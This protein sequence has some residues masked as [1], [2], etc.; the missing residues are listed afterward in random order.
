MPPDADAVHEKDLPAESPDAGHATVTINGC[1]VTVTLVLAELETPLASVAVTVTVCELFDAK[2]VEYWV[3]VPVVGLPLDDQAKL[4]GPVP[5]VAM[6]V[7]ST[8]L[9]AVAVPQLTL[10]TND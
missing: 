2:L 3:P 8:V 1:A 10:T 4:Y 6:V 7:H 5:P 9:P